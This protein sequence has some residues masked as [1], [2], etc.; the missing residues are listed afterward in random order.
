MEERSDQWAVTHAGIPVKGMAH[1]ETRDDVPVCSYL[2]TVMVLGRGEEG[3]P[4]HIGRA[5]GGRSSPSAAEALS[6]AGVRRLSFGKVAAREKGLREG[7]LVAVAHG[8][9]DHQAPD[10]GWPGTV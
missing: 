3:A 5:A 7:S 2:Q 6:F 8:C 1:A 4:G 10:F 9:P